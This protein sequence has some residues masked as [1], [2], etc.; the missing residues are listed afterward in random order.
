MGQFIFLESLTQFFPRQLR[1]HRL[2][3]PFK[4]LLLTIHSIGVVYGDLG[5]SPIYT[6]P[7]VISDL[8]DYSTAD[9]YGVTCL[10]MYSLILIVCIKYLIFVMSA[11]KKG[12]GGIL[13]LVSLVPPNRDTWK[14]AKQRP[15]FFA[16][17]RKRICLFGGF[18]GAAFILSG[19]AITPA[20]EVISAVEG[21]FSTILSPSF[22]H[23]AT[24]ISTRSYRTW[25]SERRSGGLSGS[26]QFV[27]PYLP[28]YE[29][30]LW[31][32]QTGMVFRTHHDPL[33]VCNW[34]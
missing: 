20:I 21:A 2:W 1:H 30:V 19:G 12:E 33:P 15:G 4:F 16:R 27:L 26:H 10:M 32:H 23:T 25:S 18:L 3:Q 14:H 7:T 28:I 17:W 8:G 9:L 24:L 6:Y 11:D 31:V 34:W 22:H 5:T 13:A 29:P